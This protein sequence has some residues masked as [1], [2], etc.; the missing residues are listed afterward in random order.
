MNGNIDAAGQTIPA[1]RPRA[2]LNS[3]GRAHARTLWRQ[4][5]RFVSGFQPVSLFSRALS[6]VLFGQAELPRHGR[7]LVL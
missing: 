7:V 6:L 4:P 2:V 1:F 3:P 5:G